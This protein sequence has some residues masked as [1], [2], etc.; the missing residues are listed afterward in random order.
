MIFRFLIVSDEVDDFQR[1]IIIDSEASFLDFSNAIIDSVG[2]EKDQISSFFMCEYDWSK[3][4]EIT[5]LEMD[6]TS[7]YDNYV[8]ADTILEDLIEDEGQ[9]LL[10]VF[11]YMTERAFFIELRECILGK[12][13]HK[14]QCTHTGGIAPEQFVSIDDFETKSTSLDIDENFY[15]DESYDLDEIDKEGF[16]GFSEESVGNPY[17]DQY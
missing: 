7:E 17:D 8:M 15:G 6:T 3:Q 9:K 1:E 13:L 11:D 16:D 5:L 4:T 10:Y 12:D 2:F 14:A